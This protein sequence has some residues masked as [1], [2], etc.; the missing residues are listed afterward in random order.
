MFTKQ[1]NSKFKKQKQLD[2]RVHEK[3]ILEYPI[4]KLETKKMKIA[5][6][7]RVQTKNIKI[8]AID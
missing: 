4:A 2:Q 3:I 7:K 1:L 8:L 6:G 5:I